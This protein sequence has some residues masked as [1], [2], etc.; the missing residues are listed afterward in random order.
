MAKRNK[1]SYPL[2]QTMELHM[3][4][5]MNK[6]SNC[7]TN[8]DSCIENDKNNNRDTFIDKNK[9]SSQCG[10]TTPAKLG[11]FMIHYY[12]WILHFMCLISVFH[13]AP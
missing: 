10:E 5:D 8:T 9:A 12:L 13:V 11:D 3:Y 2:P 1:H 6:G 4:I 7:D